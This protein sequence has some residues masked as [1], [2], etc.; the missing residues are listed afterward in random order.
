MSRNKNHSKTVEKR[1][2][3]DAQNFIKVDASYTKNTS[4]ADIDND[5][6]ELFDYDEESSIGRDKDETKYMS[7]MKKYSMATTGKTTENYKEL[8]STTSRA[9]KDLHKV[10]KK[11]DNG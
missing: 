11:M 9:A 6:A 4:I 5:M 1:Y 2:T 3:Q 10:Y 8:L 7:G